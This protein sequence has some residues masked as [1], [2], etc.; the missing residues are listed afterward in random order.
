MTHTSDLEQMNVKELNQL[1]I[2]RK[3]KMKILS[4]SLYEYL[5]YSSS[6][7]FVVYSISSKQYNELIAL[8]NNQDTSDI[9]KSIENAS[10]ILYHDYV[11]VKENTLVI[12]QNGEVLYCIDEGETLK[13]NDRQEI[14]SVKLD[15]IDDETDQ[16]FT[17]ETLKDIVLSYSEQED[18][19]LHKMGGQDLKKTLSKKINR[20][21]ITS[22]K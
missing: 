1:I 9:P 10:P 5:K 15:A 4:R 3:G 20:N 7:R 14:S 13:N 22:F 21:F 19:E 16:F 18:I 12:N 11:S 6:S 2:N 8:I 17:T